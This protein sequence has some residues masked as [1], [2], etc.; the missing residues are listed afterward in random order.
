MNW[1]SLFQAAY[2][3]ASDKAKQAA[4]GMMS[5]AKAAR[6]AVVSTADA[7]GDATIAAANATG[8]AIV[9]GANI[10][11][12]VSV[13]AAKATGSAIVTG[14]NVIGDAAVEV[15]KG[16]ANVARFGAR[17]VGEGAIAVGKGTT[18]PV[19]LLYQAAKKLLP[20]KPPRDVV[21]EPCSNTEAGKRKR[22]EARNRL[23]VDGK[24]PGASSE[25]LAAAK[26]L[27]RN[28]EAVDLARLSEDAYK[29]YQVPPKNDL[30]LGWTRVSDQELKVQG[31]DQLARD[32]QA[33]IYKTP[34]DWPG[35][36]KTVLAFRGT[37]D[38][39]DVIVDHDNAMGNLTGQ[40]KAAALLGSRVKEEYGSSVIVTGHSLGGG[41]AQAAGALT[42]LKGTMFNS[43]G[44]HPNTV[45]P[46]MM[47]S[48]EQFQQYRTTNDPLT[49][50]QN[51]TLAQAG[52]AG[53]AGP[54][55]VIAGLLMKGTD[56][57]AQSVGLG[58]LSTENADYAD[59]ALKL[60]P[61]ALRNVWNE[62]YVVPPAIGPV[63]EVPAIGKDGNK[64]ADLNPMGQH[65]I[66]SVVNG[67][68]EQKTEDVATL[69]GD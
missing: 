47:P 12:D 57:A 50:L 60:F 10:V 18:A 48:A 14:A 22:L 19:R 25:K 27:Q 6:E 54:L 52:V 8:R 7:V 36:Q 68:E 37:E 20:A 5:S 64:V 40:Y 16:A 51:S 44:L 32:S 59:K 49:G 67:I 29:Q 45:P 39:Q 31:L 53:S 26:R 28:N 11:E 62:G 17:V 58:R 9:M 13:S 35:G 34:A 46:G 61:R 30:P 24:T 43:A 3:A 42:G 23:I 41:K 56:L 33:V 66:I 38:T 69:R 1:G 15:G 65:S 21:I 55:A 4:I 2:D 63:F